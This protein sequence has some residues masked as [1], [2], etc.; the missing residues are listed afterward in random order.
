MKTAIKPENITGRTVK[1]IIDDAESTW[2]K[3]HLIENDR[4]LVVTVSSGKQHLAA[5]RCMKCF[6]AKL[7]AIIAAQ[8]ESLN[9]Q[10]GI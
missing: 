5:C 6:N 3:P 1:Q 2:L 7:D 8:E 9:N 4:P 10:G